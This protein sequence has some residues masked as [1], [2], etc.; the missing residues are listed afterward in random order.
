MKRIPRPQGILLDLDNTLYPYAPCHK[1]GQE[2]AW[3]LLRRHI[4]IS[5]EDFLEHYAAARRSVNNR[6]KGSASSHNR[7]L[8]FQIILENILTVTNADLLLKLYNAYWDS[9][10]D[11]IR[12][13][14][15][16]LDFLKES[17]RQG[18]RIALVT[19]LTADIQFRKL[20]RLGLEPWM[21]AVV[22]SEEAGADKPA[23]AIFLMALDKIGVSPDEAWVIGDS[24][25]KDV[26]G[27]NDLGAA[28]FWFVHTPPL[29]PRMAPQIPTRTVSSFGELAG[30]LRQL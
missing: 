13:F 24:L 4:A 21:D 26:R 3:E 20:A 1:R 30:I 23:P 8:Y 29:T 10:I 2:A 22:T 5:F 16:A 17:R 12:L 6:L 9:F 27:G 7:L 18:I 19:D 15:G 28:T 11:A 14:D 25:E